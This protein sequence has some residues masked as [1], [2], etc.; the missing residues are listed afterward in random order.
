MTALYRNYGMEEIEK[1]YYCHIIV[2]MRMYRPLF[3]PV[4]R[5]K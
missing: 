5:E 4:T 2:I 1:E 3:L